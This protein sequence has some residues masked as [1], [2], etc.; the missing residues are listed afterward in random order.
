MTKTKVSRRVSRMKNLRVSTGGLIAHPPQ[1]SATKRFSGRAR[2]VASGSTTSITR[3]NLLNHLFVNQAN[4]VTNWR[5]LSAIKLKSIHVWAA[6]P[7][8]GALSTAS[9][10]WFS[11]QGPTSIASDTAVG[12]SEPLAVHT[13]PPPNSLAGFWSYSGSNESDV[14]FTI[15]APANAVID[16]TY[17]AILANGEAAVVVTTTNNGVGGTTYMAS[18]NGPTTSTF[19]PV[20]YITLV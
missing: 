5:I 18:L 15:V 16:I 1:F 20:S 4:L 14:L 7:T 8:V 9:I 3:G 19:T 6:P 17:D 2:Y 11:A 13:S 10:E 12:Q